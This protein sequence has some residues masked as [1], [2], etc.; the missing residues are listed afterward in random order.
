MTTGTLAADMTTADRKLLHETAIALAALVEFLGDGEG[1]AALNVYRREF[2]ARFAPLLTEA[3]RSAGYRP[4]AD[5]P[6]A[7]AP[8]SPSPQGPTPESP[9]PDGT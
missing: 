9:T 7:C 4:E 2:R 3:A 8:E 6:E 5:T 1:T